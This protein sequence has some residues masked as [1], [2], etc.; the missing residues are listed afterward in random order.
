MHASAMCPG[1]LASHFCCC[2]FCC[3][4]LLSCPFPTFQAWTA[5]TWAAKHS[6]QKRRRRI[7]TLRWS[8]T[9]AGDVMAAAA[10]PAAAGRG[11]TRGAQAAAPPAQLVAARTAAAAAV[12]ASRGAAA[13]AALAAPAAGCGCGTRRGRAAR[14]AMPPAPLP[15]CARCYVLMRRRSR[16]RGRALWGRGWPCSG[17]RMRATTRYGGQRGLG[18]CGLFVGWCPTAVCSCQLLGCRVPACPQCPL[19]L[20]LT[21][22]ASALPSLP[23]ILAPGAAAG[24]AGA[25]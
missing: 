15:P 4:P 6:S 7:L 2:C 13:T 3:M 25:V 11:P 18:C 5:R 21:D 14:G 8:R 22:S 12:A 1:R 10:G 24:Q 20:S 19:R 17:M 16:L 23:F 9:A